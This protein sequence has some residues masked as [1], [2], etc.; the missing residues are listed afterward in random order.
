ME[1]LSVFKMTLQTQSTGSTFC[2]PSPGSRDLNNNIQESASGFGFGRKV[3][4]FFTKSHMSSSSSEESTAWE[5]ISNFFKGLYERAV[6]LVN[7]VSRHIGSILPDYL[8]AVGAGSAVG[9]VIGLLTPIGPLW[10]TLGGYLIAS[11]FHLCVECNKDR[12][13]PDTSQTVM[14]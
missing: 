1:K 11:G 4:G 13:K 8:L 10:G 14:V 9:F 5:S 2:A 3:I 12:D 7:Y 6:K